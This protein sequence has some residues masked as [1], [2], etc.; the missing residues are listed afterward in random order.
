[1]TRHEISKLFDAYRATGGLNA[2][3]ESPIAQELTS[4]VLGESFDRV[5]LIRIWHAFDI[6]VGV[7]S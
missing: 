3:L 5:D 6:A 2:Y 1:M 4:R 7:V